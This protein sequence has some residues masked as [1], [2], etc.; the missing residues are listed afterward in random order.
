MAI[1]NCLGMSIFST[2]E[3]FFCCDSAPKKFIDYFWVSANLVSNVQEAFIQDQVPGSD[4]APVGL[5][6]EM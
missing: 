2:K 3:D 6:L 4:H 1:A 5:A